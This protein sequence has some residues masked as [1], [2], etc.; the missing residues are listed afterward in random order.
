MYESHLEKVE[1][2]LRF[3]PWFEALYVDYRTVLDNP[4]TE[5]RRINDFLGGRLDERRMVEAVDPNLYRN[6]AENLE[7]TTTAA[8]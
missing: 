3:R 6:R 7:T 5:A 8:S 4:E 1:F 2:Q